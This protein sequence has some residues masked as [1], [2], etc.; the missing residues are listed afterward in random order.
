MV[1]CMK[2]EMAS[3]GSKV[4]ALLILL[5]IFFFSCVSCNGVPCPPN[6]P[7]APTVPKSPPK[8]PAPTVPTPPPKK[9]AKCPKDTLKF[10]ACANWLGLVGEVVGT[11]PSSKCCALVAGLADLEAALCFCTAIKANVLGLSRLKCL[12]P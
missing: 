4:A 6:T 1:C 8:K 2:R 7:P 5:N 12:W 9:S 3:W 10:G 11:P